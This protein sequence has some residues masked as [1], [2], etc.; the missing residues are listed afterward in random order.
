MSLSEAERMVLAEAWAAACKASGLKLILV[1]WNRAHADVADGG[2]SEVVPRQYSVWLRV[3]HAPTLTP[4]PTPTPAPGHTAQHIGCDSLESART[5]AAHAESLSGVDAI[6][7]MAPSF[8]RPTSAAALVDFLAPVA[9]AAPN[10]PFF[11][12]HFPS[13]TNCT[14]NASE[15]FKEAK[16]TGRIPTLAGMK[17]TVRTPGEGAARATHSLSPTPTNPANSAA[18]NP[19]TSVRRELY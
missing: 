8:F 19:T 10:T 9:A 7:G 18:L 5:L 15:F 11:Y 3:S 17:Y 2:Y 16:E 1:R 14:V 13:I 6:A 4:T 12:Y